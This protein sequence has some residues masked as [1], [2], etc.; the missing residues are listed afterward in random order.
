MVLGGQA[1]FCEQSL[2]SK[3]TGQMMVM[4]KEEEEGEEEGCG[5]EGDYS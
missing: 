1:S 4:K 2:P 5:E 3:Q